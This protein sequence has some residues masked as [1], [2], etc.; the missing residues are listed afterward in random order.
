MSGTTY[1]SI[2]VIIISI[3]IHLPVS[4]CHANT[5]AC[6][7][8]LSG[9]RSQ[10]PVRKIALVARGRCRV[11]DDTL[12]PANGLRLQSPQRRCR[13]NS[14]HT[15]LHPVTFLVAHSILNL[16]C[17]KRRRRRYDLLFGILLVAT[18]VAFGSGWLR[19]NSLYMPYEQMVLHTL[20]LVSMLT[21][22]VI[23]LSE[24]HRNRSRVEAETGGDIMPYVRYTWAGYLLFCCTSLALVG[25]IMWRPLLF[26]IGPAVLLSAVIFNLSFVA[27]G[28]NLAPIDEVLTDVADASQSMDDGDADESASDNA[29]P[30]QLSPEMVRIVE[31]ALAA[32]CAEK[33]FRDT[34]VNMVKL[35]Q[36]TGVVR[37]TLSIYFDQHLHTT[38][39]IW[40]SDIRF[41]EAQDYIMAHPEYTNESV[42]SA[43]GFTSRSHLYKIFND[44]TGM[45]PREWRDGQKA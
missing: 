26:V 25:A 37:R 45:T 3:T 31:A 20:Y 22:I 42:S 18:F 17:E 11:A 28:Y 19:R 29:A 33:N 12:R 21:S 39:R 1:Q 40:L 38:F 6:R 8:T 15:V 24:I 4:V 10:P 14:K 16:E 44:R 35:S 41:K 34:T 30:E 23:P 36:S 2:N 32:W 27:M 13:R 43:C 7:V 5:R 9:V